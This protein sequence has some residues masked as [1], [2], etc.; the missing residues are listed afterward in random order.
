MGKLGYKKYAIG[1]LLVFLIIVQ[2]IAYNIKNKEKLN[3]FEKSIL[4]IALPMQ[5]LI[6]TAQSKIG[7]VWTGYIFL[8]KL[9]GENVDLNI[10]VDELESKLGR[11]TEVEAENKRL[12]DLLDFADESEDR[13]IAAR[14]V[15]TGPSNFYHTLIINRGSENAIKRGMA[16]LTKSGVVGQISYVKKGYSGVITLVDPNSAIDAINQTTRARGILRGTR[17]RKLIFKYLPFSERVNIGDRVVSSGMDRIYPKGMLV[18]EIESVVNKKENLFQ[19]VTVK[20]A[21]DFSKLEEVL[22]RLESPAK[23]EEKE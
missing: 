2:L 5:N 21:V 6:S 13:Y 16:V 17:F 9:S 23:S 22:V 15:T 8:V 10:R 1:S 12:K 18:G 7:D 19:N 14:V 20:P 3:F 4:F 11:M